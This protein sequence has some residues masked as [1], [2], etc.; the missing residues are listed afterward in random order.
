A[1]T[2][3]AA[4]VLG[5]ADRIGSLEAGKDA[6]VVVFDGD[7]LDYRTRVKAVLLG[8]QVLTFD[9]QVTKPGRI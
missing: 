3:S 9:K 6:D 8:G 4:E 7:P 2:L 1:I 5:V